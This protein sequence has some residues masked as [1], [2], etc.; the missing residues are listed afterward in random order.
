MPRRMPSQAEIKVYESVPCRGIVKLKLRHN[1][2]FPT[3][4]RSMGSDLDQRAFD[5]VEELGSDPARG[6]TDIEDFN[7]GQDSRI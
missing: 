5:L 7:L 1:S 4:S 2:E 3:W 6:V